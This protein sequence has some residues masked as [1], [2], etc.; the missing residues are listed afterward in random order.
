M[1]MQAFYSGNSFDAYKFFGAHL[2]P[3][4]SEHPRGALFRTFAPAAAGIVLRLYSRD[5]SGSVREIP[6]MRAYDGNAWEVHA[7]DVLPG[8]AYEFRIYTHSGEFV[9][10]ADPF[11]I[12]S[13][14]RP[15]HRSI[16]RERSSYQFDDKSWMESRSACFNQ[17]LNIFEVHTGSWRKPRNATGEEQPDLWYRYDELAEPLI[18][19]C[20]AGG[21]THVEFLPLS[22]HP[23]DE[24]WGYQ[25]SGF[26]SPTSRY[27]TLDELKCLINRLH[28]AGIGAILDFVPVHFALDTWGLARYDGTPLFEYPN[29]DVGV[30]EWGSSNFMHSRGEV[31]SFLKSA[32][33]WWLEEVHFDGIR[34][35]A[36]SRIIY[37]QGDEKRGVN[38]MAVDFIRTMNAGL[39]KR[40]PGCMLIAED[41]TNY[42]GVTRAV[43]KGGL[44]FDYKWDM[45]WMHDTLSFLQMP[46]AERSENYHKLTFS[47]AYFGNERYLLPFSH[48]EV[49]HGK[50]TVLQKMQGDYEGKFPQARALYVYMTAHPGKMLNFMG[51]EFGQLREWDEK[52][53]QDWLLLDFPIHD[54]FWRFWRELGQ[55]YRAN[56]ALWACDYEADG[57]AWIDCHEESWLLYAFERRGKG[58]RIICMLNLGNEAQEY[59]LCAPSDSEAEAAGART[60]GDSKLEM[61]IYTDWQRYGGSTP[62]EQLCIV[63][64]KE[65]YTCHLSPYSGMLVRLR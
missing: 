48:D 44:G 64:G 51:S 46:V 34:V 61:L 7:D 59:E 11:A 31:R 1:D 9:D 23:A 33:N 65:G 42:P 49:V 47:M 19:H 58:E 2:D 26:F 17:P 35:D 57:F 14:L 36:L 52:R 21:F 53:E 43:D 3:A 45:G 13:D 41:S 5:D 38:G 10:H 37:W 54:A 20:R 18:A 63:P 55:V 32:A 39:K 28:N 12:G 8:D 4:D 40:H 50:A 30:S 22:E 62:D 16:V 15:R 24:S 27:G 25:P 29:Q 60:E 56:P 6:M